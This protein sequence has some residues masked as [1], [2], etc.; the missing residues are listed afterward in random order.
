[1]ILKQIF[2]VTNGCVE[3]RLYWLFI[4]LFK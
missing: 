1:M 2:H 3:T 4:N